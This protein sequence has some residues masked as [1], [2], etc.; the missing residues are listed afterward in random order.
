MRKVLWLWYR[1]Q[2]KQEVLTL[3]GFIHQLAWRW[4]FWTWTFWQ[5]LLG[6]WLFARCKRFQTLSN[7]C[8]ILCWVKVVVSIL[9]LHNLSIC[10]LAIKDW[11]F[12]L[13]F[14]SLLSQGSGEFFVRRCLIKLNSTHLMHL[15]EFLEMVC[16]DRLCSVVMKKWWVVTVFIWYLNWVGLALLFSELFGGGLARSQLPASFHWHHLDLVEGILMSGFRTH[17]SLITEAVTLN[18]IAAG[19]NLKLTHWLLHL[20]F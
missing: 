15:L 4:W 18:L 13:S 5:S 10:L 6:L 9:I 2:V 7:P 16:F 17:G 3:L 8:L 14:A 20:V 1:R 12:M 11:F 19:S